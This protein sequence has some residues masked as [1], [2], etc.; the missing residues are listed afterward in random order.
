MTRPSGGLF[1]NVTTPSPPPPF[2][3]SYRSIDIEERV[4][5]IGSSS[6]LAFDLD[7]AISTCAF[8]FDTAIATHRSTAKTGSPSP[9]LVIAD[10][11]LRQRC[12]A[13]RPYLARNRWTLQHPHSCTLRHHPGKPSI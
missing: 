12:I 8:N 6:L 3:I 13:T 2:I 1:P 9:V 5:A 4:T 7:N 11:R 10:F